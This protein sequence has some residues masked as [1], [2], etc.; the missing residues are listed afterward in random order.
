MLE[1]TYSKVEATSDLY[2]VYLTF[3]ADCPKFIDVQAYIDPNHEDINNL[4]AIYGVS[5]LIKVD[6]NLINKLMEREWTFTVV[7]ECNEF[8]VTFTNTKCSWSITVI[9]LELSKECV[10][11]IT[12]ECTEFVNNIIDNWVSRNG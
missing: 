11:T 9:Y 7:S 2:D 12:E 10:I 3:D 1:E 6:A 8:L 5:D 4:D